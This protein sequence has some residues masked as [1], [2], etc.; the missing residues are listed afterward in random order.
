MDIYKVADQ[1]LVMGWASVAVEKTGEVLIDSQDDIIDPQSLEEA[2]Y[3]FVLDFRD[4][5]EMHTGPIKGQLVESLVVTKQK[6]EAMGL[7]DDALPVG[8]WVGFKVDDD[9]FAKVKDGTLR[10]FSIEGTG[11]RV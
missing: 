9:T 11:E 7:P 1:N 8:W 6:L 4:A 10:A 3:E 5:N 2:V